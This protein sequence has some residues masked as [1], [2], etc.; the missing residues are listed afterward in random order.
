MS[1][2]GVTLEATTGACAEPGVAPA[3][4]GVADAVLGGRV[5]LDVPVQATLRPSTAMVPAT[6]TRKRVEDGITRNIS[7]PGPAL[8]RTW[9]MLAACSFV[10]L[11][12]VAAFLHVP[13][14][15]LGS[16]EDS[17]S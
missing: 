2:I 4:R 8:I 7:D 15:G 6:D 11:A 14:T 5:A 13:G 1:V 3:V 12:N 9:L 10:A 17:G 16:P